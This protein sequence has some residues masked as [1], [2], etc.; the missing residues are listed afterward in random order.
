MPLSLSEER[1]QKGSS[2]GCQGVLW[3]PQGPS[4]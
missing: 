1:I 4:S 2:M 3:D